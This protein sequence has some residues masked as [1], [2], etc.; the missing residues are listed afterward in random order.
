MLSQMST[1]IG[2]KLFGEIEV[3]SMFKEIKHMGKCPMLDKPVF[4][5][6]DCG[7]LSQKDLKESL[8][9]VNLIK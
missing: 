3:A 4:G 8:E 9:V 6:V 2:I 7:L 5:P 1:K